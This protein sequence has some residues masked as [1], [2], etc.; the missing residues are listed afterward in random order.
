MS[1]QAKNKI[2]KTS[3]M[4]KSVDSK[5]VYKIKSAENDQDVP[6]FTLPV[7]LHLLKPDLKDSLSS[8]KAIEGFEQELLPQVK[9]EI[10]NLCD[11]VTRFTRASGSYIVIYMYQIGWFLQ[12][13]ERQYLLNG[14]KKSDYI[15]W[16]KRSFKTDKLRYFQQCRQLA[17]MER[18]P[19][20]LAHLGKKRILELDYLLEQFNEANEDKSK[21]QLYKELMKKYPFPP[22]QY[23]KDG[24]LFRVHMDA[25]ITY[26]R[27]VDAKINEKHF[28]FYHC[29]MVAFIRKKAIEVAQATQLANWLTSEDRSGKRHKDLVDVY[30]MN[31]LIPP[32]KSR[33]SNPKNVNKHLGSFVKNM[34]TFPFSDKSQLKVVD[35]DTVKEA[36]ECLQ[37]LASKLGIKSK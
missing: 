20:D 12:A 4:V 10:V 19:I 14:K 8:E 29:K 22:E 16:V 11:N 23:D 25:I 32:R 27:L 13:V 17:R 28:E 15:A 5:E 21:M 36:I 18:L 26:F 24:E 34:R 7:Q 30:V 35:K 1:Q 9:N 2:K 33:Q 6:L 3:A 37:L 31:K